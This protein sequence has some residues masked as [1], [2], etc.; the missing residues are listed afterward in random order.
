MRIH[1]PRIQLEWSP[2]IGLI[3]IGL[4]LATETFSCMA[5]D[6]PM[7]GRGHHRNAVVPDENA[8]VDWQLPDNEMPARNIR[9]S[10]ELGTVSNGDPVISNG[11]VWVGT[12]NGRPRN[13]Q[14]KQDAGVLICFDEIDGRFLYQYVSQRIAGREIDWPGSSQCGSPLI[15]NGKLWFCNTRCEVICLDI[16]PLIARTGDAEVV[17]NVNLREQFGVVPRAIMIGSNASQCSIASYRELIYVNTTNAAGYTRVLAPNAPSLICFEKQTG[18]VKWQDNSPGENLLGVQHGSPMVAEIQGQA[19]VIMG[20]GE[21]WVRGFDALTGELL[22]KFDINPKSFQRGLGLKNQRND[23]VAMPVFYEGNVYFATGRHYES[24]ES[25]GRVYCLDP[26]KRGDISHEL[27]DL[28][29]RA[30]PNPNSGMVWQYSGLSVG[31]EMHRTLSSVA[32]H[33]GLLFVSDMKST[34]HCIDAATGK[35][36]WT[37]DLSELGNPFCSPLIVGSRV[38]VCAQSATFVFDLAREKRVIAEHGTVRSC[39]SSPAYAN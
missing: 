1:S 29:A 4:V 26:T 17:W 2:W 10:T 13:T 21:G 33:K 9:W 12:N 19:Q 25:P 30:L 34:L 6:W 5:A 7:R 35:G 20:Q 38:Y 23:L 28:P 32:L 3:S 39:E 24:D 16:A 31:D 11:L 22:W 15:E 27:G 36:I 18:R 14:K 8:P 37:H